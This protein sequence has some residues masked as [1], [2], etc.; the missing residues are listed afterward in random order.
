MIP[1]VVDWVTTIL[2][3]VD[4]SCG[5]LVRSSELTTTPTDDLSANDVEGENGKSEHARFKK[6]I[7]L[8]SISTPTNSKTL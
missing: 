5:I 4:I 2:E 1:P 8:A 7:M 6:Y 3:L